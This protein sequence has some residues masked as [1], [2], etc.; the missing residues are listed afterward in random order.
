V[1]RSAIAVALFLLATAR[2]EA[3][4]DTLGV[5]LIRPAARRGLEKQL[6]VTRLGELTRYEIDQA[7]DDQSG[8]FSAQVVV[9]WTNTTG[10]PVP[11]LPVLL[12]PNAAA[13]LGVTQGGTGSITVSEVA[14]VSGPRV[15]H[16]VVRPTLL[17]VRFASAVAPGARVAIRL[18]YAGRLRVLGPR[19]NDAFAQAMAG[20]GSL[21]SSDAS[22]YGLLAMGDGLITIAS[23]YPMIAPFRDGAFD[24]GPPSRLGDVAY[25]NVAS[26]RV[27]TVVPDGVDLVTNLVDAASAPAPGGGRLFASEGA[28]VRDFVLVAGR[29]LQRATRRVG[30]VTVTSV[31]R[32]RDAAG[33]RTA[34]D[35]AADALVSLERRFGPYPYRELDVVEASLAGGAGGVEFSSLVL[36]AGMLYRPPDPSQSPLGGLG[37]MMG[38]LGGL[39]GMLNGAAPGASTAAPSPSTSSASATNLMAGM[40]EFTV[41]HEVAHQWFAGIVGNDSHRFPSLDEPL[42]QYAAALVVEDRQGAAAGRRAMDLNV[43]MNYAL[44]R[45]L[46]GADR[47][48]LRDTTSYRTPVEYAALVYGKAPYLYVDLRRTLGDATLHRAIRAAV[49]RHRYRLVTTPDWIT[50]IASTAPPRRRPAVRATFTRYLEQ[51]HGDADLGVTDDGTFVIDTLFPP[52]VARA[53]RQSTAMLG[54]SPRDLLRQLFGGGLGDDAPTGTG[55]DPD[56]ALRR[57]LGQ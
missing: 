2:A 24:D 42:A 48:V 11:E 9:H 31:F 36:I 49:D 38:Q 32:A 28:L 25:N 30:D 19:A 14:S 41:A 51:T 18:R 56:A 6:G 53:L 4:D 33:G 23:A 39:G 10:R 47:A 57:M 7:L 3:Q 27:R 5:G 54:M 35:V 13:E 44:Y 8:T 20:M 22:D 15:T 34:L 55:L 52:D 21:A 50:A 12:H 29:D 16:T 45:M 1:I 43:K 17:R 26:F 37:A 46:G 40:L